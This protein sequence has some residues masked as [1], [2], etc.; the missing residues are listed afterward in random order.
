MTHETRVLVEPIDPCAPQPGGVDTCI[1]GLIKFRDSD[2]EL[3]L[4]G[5]DSLGDRQLGQWH[6]EEVDGQ[7][8]WFLPVYRGDTSVLR[9][10]VPHVAR[11]VWG[12]WRHRARLAE[13]GTITL[14]THRVT[15]GY[16]L[17]KLFPR[18]TRVQFVHN[19]GEETVSLG[20]ESYFRRFKRLFHHIERRTVL[21]STDTVVFNRKAAQRLSAWGGHV[22]FSPTWFDD[23]F[24]FP[25]EQPERPRT[26]LLWVGRL[27]QTKDPILALEA[28]SL[29]DDRYHLTMLGSGSLR[30]AAQRRADELGVGSRVQL[31]GAVAKHE[32]ADYLR[33][34]QL[35]LMTS[36]HEGFPRAVVEALASGL[37]VVTTRGGEPNGLVVDGL[38]G[39]RAE[40][41][42]PETITAAI[43]RAEN[44][45]SESAVRSVR[46]LRA[47]I[48]VPYVLTPDAP[49]VD[50]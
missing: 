8:V 14:Q 33:Q 26:A 22:R 1:R 42:A 24:F 27:E 43:Q 35:L 40:D 49:E 39:T 6:R 18:V 17:N 5:V 37:P 23:E 3:R 10:R 28:F 21:T 4:I 50:W 20:S 48:L 16:A 45:T 30:D 38:N 15:T 11:L 34:S 19:D 36:V 41:R 47:S 13:L 32:V 7:P 44:L 9:P 46:G 12:L 29:L 25:S 2:V 31:V